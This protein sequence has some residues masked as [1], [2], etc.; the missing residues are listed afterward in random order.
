MRAERS[1]G[2]T[3]TNTS[4]STRSRLVDPIKPLKYF[5][6]VFRS[7]SWTLV[8]DFYHDVCLVSSDPRADRQPFAAVTNRVVYEVQ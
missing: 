7:D 8:G 1:D 2:Q 3:Q 6:P 5:F 4:A